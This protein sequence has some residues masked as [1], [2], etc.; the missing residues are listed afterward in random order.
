MGRVGSYPTFS[1][2]LQGQEL[3][4]QRY[5]SVALVL[6]SPPAGVTRYPYPVKPGLSSRSAFQPLPAAVR[7]GRGNIVAQGKRIVKCLANSFR[8]GYTILEW[9]ELVYLPGGA[10]ALPLPMGEVPQFANWG[11]E[12]K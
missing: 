12:G 1:P 10:A 3:P 4:L 5:I 8:R 6:G 9:E 2:L 7:P 11:G